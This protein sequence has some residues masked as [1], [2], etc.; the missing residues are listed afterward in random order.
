MRIRVYFFGLYREFAG[1]DELMLELP[2][3]ATV[4]TA[5]QSLRSRGDG[6]TR[7]PEV[8]SVA[9]NEVYAHIDAPLADG[10]EL[11]FLPPVA[12]G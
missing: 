10:D 2:E 3:S 1:S 9:V 4:A 11:A 12:G 5:V 7:L 8:P 6:L